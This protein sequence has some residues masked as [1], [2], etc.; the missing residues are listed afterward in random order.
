M[1]CQ[2]KRFERVEGLLLHGPLVMELLTPACSP[3]SITPDFLRIVKMTL[4]S[5]LSADTH[6]AF[7]ELLV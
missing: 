4:F 5:K 3:G 1:S 6:P 2:L 7:I